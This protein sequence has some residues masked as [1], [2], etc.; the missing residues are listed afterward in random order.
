MVGAVNYGS[1]KRAH[2]QQHQV[3]GKTGTCIED[4]T[5]V[6]LFASYAP[7]VNPKLAVVVITRGS[8]ARRHFPA[9]VA[10]SI[11]RELSNQHGVPSGLNVASSRG[12]RA[13]DPD[14]EEETVLE[15]EAEFR[16]QTATVFRSDQSNSSKVKPVLMSIPTPRE[17]EKPSTQS[18]DGP[19][20]TGGQTR[21]RRVLGE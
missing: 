14:D 3:A 21:P 16:V 15:E 12:D 2:D 5:W 10:G 9:A 8:D 6:G 20:V 13:V 19:L 11:Y 7:V 17:V 1:G 4:G 18:S